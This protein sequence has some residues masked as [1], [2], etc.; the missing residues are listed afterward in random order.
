MLLR[1][2]RFGF[3]TGV[4]SGA[5]RRNYA[6]RSVWSI[7]WAPMGPSREWPQQSARHRQRR[8]TTPSTITRMRPPPLQCS[9]LRIATAQYRIPLAWCQV[10][11]HV[12][13]TNTFCP[14]PCTPWACLIPFT[15]VCRAVRRP[16]FNRWISTLI[17]PLRRLLQLLRRLPTANR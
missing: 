9:L 8:S 17:R 4:P 3:P 16:A 6:P 15:T 5:G 1:L 7:K 12:T 2:I 14:I 13:T 11:R 10:N